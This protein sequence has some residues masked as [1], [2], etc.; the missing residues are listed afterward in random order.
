LGSLTYRN[1]TSAD[2]PFM[3]SLIAEDDVG[4]QMDDPANPNSTEYEA[5]LAAI[6]ADPNQILYV[7][8]ADGAVIGTFQLTFIPGIS[9]KGMWRAVIESV[10]VSP[11][12]RNKGYGKEMIRWAVDQSRARGCGMVQ[13]TSNKKRVDAHRFYRTLGFDQSHEGF[14]LFL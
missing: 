12:H 2:L 11:A 10:H 6:D 4:I 3:V 14:K 8:E 9:R 7:V 13:L 1:A 5:A